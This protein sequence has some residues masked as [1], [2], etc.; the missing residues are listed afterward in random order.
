MT[1]MEAIDKRISRRSYINEPI[2]ES[3]VQILQNTINQYN[4]LSGLSIQLVE[5]GREAFNGFTRSYG[6]LSGVRSFFALVGKQDDPDLLEKAGYYGELLVLDATRLDL[7]TCWVGASF[8]KKHCKC[9]IEDDE[10]LVCVITVGLTEQNKSMREKVI[11]KF[12]H[13]SSKSPEQLYKADGPVPDWFT[14][15]IEAV[16]KAPSAMNLQPVM[17]TYQNGIVTAAAVGKSP[18]RMIDLGIAKAH[19]EIAA[20]GRFSFGNDGEFAKA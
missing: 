19:F 18:Y 7:G 3:S 4:E 11:Y 10:R 1:L 12:T 15:G 8:S 2:P 20:N 14:A 17:F 16:R 9:R 5:D 6:M 13:R